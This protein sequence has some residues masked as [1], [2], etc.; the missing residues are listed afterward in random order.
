MATTNVRSKKSSRG[1]AARWVCAG[2]RPIIG[3]CNCMCAFSDQTVGHRKA[4]AAEQVGELLVEQPA[5]GRDVGVAE[6]AELV[7]GL[8][9]REV[10]P[11][12]EVFVEAQAE[13]GVEHDGRVVAVHGL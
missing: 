9:D 4:K 6:A 2:S 1:V 5:G 13:W 8:V 12:V 11:A 3:T 7:A 10:G